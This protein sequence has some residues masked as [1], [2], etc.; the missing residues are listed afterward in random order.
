[1]AKCADCRLRDLLSVTGRDDG[2]HESFYPA[3]LANDNL[4]ILVVAREVRE[5]ARCTGHNVHVSRAEQLDQTLH[6]GLHVV[7]QAFELLFNMSSHVITYYLLLYQ[8]C[9]GIR[10]ISQRP[11]TVLH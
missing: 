8:F 6:Q 10:E 2:P 5:D 3:H 9:A 4:V 11:Q 7:L 1:M